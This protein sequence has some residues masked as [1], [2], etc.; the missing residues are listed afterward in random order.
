MS[1]DNRSIEANHD[2]IEGRGGF[3]E[4]PSGLVE[5]NLLD[6]GSDCADEPRKSL[7]IAS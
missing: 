4:P 7:V 3:L 1:L 5:A 2:L 6:A